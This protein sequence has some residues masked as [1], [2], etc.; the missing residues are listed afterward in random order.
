MGG[1]RVTREDRLSEKVY[2]YLFVYSEKQREDETKNKKYK[3][4]IKQKY[5][6][7]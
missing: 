2:I 3:N 1:E 5:K 4:N 7:N 6:I